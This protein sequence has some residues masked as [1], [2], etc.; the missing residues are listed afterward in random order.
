MTVMDVES[1]FESRLRT[2]LLDAQLTFEV[3]ELLHSADVDVNIDDDGAADDRDPRLEWAGPSSS[4]Q[5]SCAWTAPGASGDAEAPVMSF[6]VAAAHEAVAALVAAPVSGRPVDVAAVLRMAEQLRGL[7]LQFLGEMEVTGSHLADGAPTTATWLR[8]RQLLSDAG[9][10]AQVRLAAAL[11]DDLPGVGAKVRAGDT[12]VEHARAAVAGTA[13]LD[14][15]VVRDSDEAIC[16]LLASTDPQT[17]RTELRER[18]EAISPELGRN[19]EKRAHERRGISLDPTKY[20]YLLGGS[21]GVEDGQ[22]VELGFDLAIQADRTDGDRRTLSQRRADVIV[23]WA[24]QAAAE[25][26]GPAGSVADDVR[27]TRTHLLLTCTADQL[28]AARAWLAGVGSPAARPVQPGSADDVAGSAWP[29]PFPADGVPRGTSCREPA[30]GSFAPGAL[31]STAALRRLVCDAA[32][33]LAVQSARSTTNGGPL[34]LRPDHLRRRPNPLYVGRATRLV[35]AAQ[36]KALLLRDRHCVV[37]GCRRRPRQCEAHHV[38][39]WLNGG[40]TDLDNLVLLCFLHH[41]EHH[42]R[43]RDLQHRDGRWMTSSGWAPHAPP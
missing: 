15:D 23:Q 24:R 31:V 5:H 7:A 18:A 2:L 12:T 4:D 9:A 28:E 16:G 20:G 29:W 34:G 35:T 36:W 32:V 25:Q 22:I 40:R 19:A 38:L 13:G 8:D 21:L 39:H 1:V 10:R 14:R 17:V 37:K 41:H 6:E 33:S 27:T 26:A 30:G 3:D 42:D 43:G 11:R